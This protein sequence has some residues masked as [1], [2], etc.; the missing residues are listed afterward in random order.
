MAVQAGC[1]FFFLKGMAYLTCDWLKYECGC[2]QS[3]V[4]FGGEYPF[5]VQYTI[6]FL[7]I[8][9]FTTEYKK[10]TVPP[11]TEKFQ[12]EGV[13]GWERKSVKCKYPAS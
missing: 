7:H 11:G 9:C 2:S 13:L 8:V 1:T 5:F 6:D 12:M 10:N 3:R 4:P